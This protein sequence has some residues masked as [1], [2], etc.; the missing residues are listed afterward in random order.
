MAIK[1]YDVYRSMTG[2]KDYVRGDTREMD[3]LDAAELIRSGALALPGEK[4]AVREPAVVH[5]FGSA[6]SPNAEIVLPPREQSVK[7]ADQRKS[8][9]AK[10]KDQAKA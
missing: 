9:A 6:P 8:A 10:A 4:P 5:A 7:V 1:T 3:E 2:D